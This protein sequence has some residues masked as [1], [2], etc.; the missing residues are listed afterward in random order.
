[1]RGASLGPKG[2]SGGLQVSVARQGDALIRTTLQTVANDTGGFLVRGT[3]DLAGGL[4]RM[5]AD[6]EAYY[7]LAYG[8]AG[9]K[10]D[11]LFHRIELRLPRR[12]QLAVRTR[13]GCDA[14]QAAKV[15]AR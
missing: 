7:L 12:P 4:R 15:A 9:Q 14:A 1:M 10:R 8:P 5:L 11:E 3:N 6:N 2:S 13:K